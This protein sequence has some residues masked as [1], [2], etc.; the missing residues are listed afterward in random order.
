MLKKI[1]IIIFALI[2]SNINAAERPM[3]QQEKIALQQQRLQ[4]ALNIQK[5]LEHHDLQEEISSIPQPTIHNPLSIYGNDD[6]IATFWRYNYKGT[7]E[8]I[9]FS[10][11]REKLIIN[12]DRAFGCTFSFDIPPS[13]KH[14]DL[15]AHAIHGSTIYFYLNHEIGLIESITDNKGSTI[16]WLH[17]A[18]KY[19]YHGLALATL[20]VGT[21]WLC[22]KSD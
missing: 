2:C 19:T 13:I 9:S 17:P 7:T 12:I 15:T 8:H 3:T 16:K 10:P 5:Q 6:K 14:V 21:W 20:A 18:R 1:H 22:S 4:F 11:N